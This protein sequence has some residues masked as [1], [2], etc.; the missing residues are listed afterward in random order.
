VVRT[1]H[2]IEPIENTE[3]ITK[4]IIVISGMPCATRPVA[5][6]AEHDESDGVRYDSVC[7]AP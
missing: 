3:P 1:V 5:A 4:A 2:Q 7:P 6:H